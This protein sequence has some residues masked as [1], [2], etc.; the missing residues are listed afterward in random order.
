[1]RSV[2]RLLSP[3]PWALL[4]LALAPPAAHGQDHPD[5]IGL[6][7][8]FKSAES[9]LK[10][11]D[12]VVGRA[13]AFRVY[14][15]D[16]V[17]GDWVWLISTGVS[18]WAPAGD[19][20]RFEQAID[21]YSAMINHDPKDG[22]AFMNRGIC[23]AVR[24]EFDIAITDIDEA[25]RLQPDNSVAFAARGFARERKQDIRQAIDDYT[26]ALRLNPK[27]PRC[28][29][30][31]GNAHRKLKEYREAL[32]DYDEAVR[33]DPSLADALAN[34]AWVRATC[35]D[36]AFRDGKQ[37]VESATRAC[38]LVGWRAA[39]LLDVLAAAHAEIRDFDAAVKWARAALDNVA[40][41][42][43]D[44]R[45]RFQMHLRLYQEKKPLREEAPE[46]FRP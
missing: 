1:M 11:G 34:R 25:I 35:P 44:S 40:A 37:A 39:A 24:G 9:V 23:W 28:L 41:G 21:F 7:V 19:L 38:E 12:K 36:P 27:Y 3:L 2:P 18:G 6:Q 31:R 29:C 26:E 33:Q 22:L 15:I 17:N 20:V 46:Q 4:V 45:V 43:S 10:I 30:L 16:R 42:E 32:S 14:R 5:W 8:I 13:D